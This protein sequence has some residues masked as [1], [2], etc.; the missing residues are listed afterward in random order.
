MGKDVP[1]KWNIEKARVLILIPEKADFKPKLFR[2]DNKGHF[3]I[4]GKIHQ[5]D[6][7]IVNIYAFSIDA[8]VSQNKHYCT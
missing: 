2:R 5:E 3:L 7:T 4:K 1:S 8:P 6:I